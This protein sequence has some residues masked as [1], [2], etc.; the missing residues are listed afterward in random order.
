MEKRISLSVLALVMFCV[1]YSVNLQAPLYSVYAE[2]SNMGPAAVAIAFAAYVLGLLPTLLMLGGISNKVGRKQPIFLALLLS[3]GATALLVI[4]PNWTSLFV[5]RLLLGVAT[6]LTTT[7]VSAYIYD[8]IDEREQKFGTLLVAASTSL[9]FGSG[10]LATSVSLNV[11][12]MTVLPYSYLSLFLLVSLLLLLLVRLPSNQT[13]KPNLKLITLPCFPTNTWSYGLGMM[14]AWATTGMVIAIVPILLNEMGLSDWTGLMVFLSI[15]TGFLT[16]HIAKRLHPNSSLILGCF[17]TVFGFSLIALGYY[18]ESITIILFGASCTSLSSYGFTYMA[19][20]LKFTSNHN[21]DKASS[22]AGMYIYSYVGFSIPVITSGF[23]AQ[24]F[25]N[26]MAILSFLTLLL[27]LCFI[28]V[29][30]K[31]IEG[32]KQT[33]FMKVKS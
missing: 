11:A 4:Q 2:N 24:R 30:G 1:T 20:L 31:L 29:V 16:Q 7:S 14:L 22:T 32:K 18:H 21:I 27:A 19:G 17:F 8:L 10:A 28:I 6:A 26:W 23:I 13:I 9:G 3:A 15:C 12:G 33:H 5:A 25:G